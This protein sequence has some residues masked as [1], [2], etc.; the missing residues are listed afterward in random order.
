[1]CKVNGGAKDV[2]AQWSDAILTFHV[3]NDTMWIQKMK[4]IQFSEALIR[5][6]NVSFSICRPPDS[7]LG[8]TSSP[9][10]VYEPRQPV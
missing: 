8:P 10:E 6:W 5:L 9:A 7:D 3:L 2:T 4:H 1:M